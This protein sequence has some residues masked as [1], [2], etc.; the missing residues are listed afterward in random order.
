M[1]TYTHYFVALCLSFMHV[2]KSSSLLQN[3]YQIPVTRHRLGYVYAD[4]IASA[5]V[6]IDMFLCLQSTEDGR[7]LQVILDTADH[8]GPRLVRLSLHGFPLPHVQ[9][10]YLATRATRVV[11]SLMPKKTVEYMQSLFQDKIEYSVNTTESDI[12]NALAELATGLSSNITRDSFYD[13]FEDEKT[14]HLCVYEWQSAILRGVYQTPW[15]LINDMPILDF[16]PD[17][18]LSNWTAIIDPLLED[19]EEPGVGP[20]LPTCLPGEPGCVIE[21]PCGTP[22]AAPIANYDWMMVVLAAL[23]STY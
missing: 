12:I 2:V 19:Y 1:A 13:K 14:G 9:S 5:P 22:N 4:G 11:D 18:T 20:P 16:R 10:S 23:T 7:P 8:Y 17:W 15:F 21:P 6:Q 3:Y